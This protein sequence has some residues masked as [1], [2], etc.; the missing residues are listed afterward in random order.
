[1]KIA[2]CTFC[3]MRVIGLF[4]VAFLVT[5]CVAQ[6]DS[7][8]NTEKLRQA[9]AAYRHAEYNTAVNL[10][11]EVAATGLSTPALT[12]NTA[13]T[14]YQLGYYG[15]ALGEYRKALR[16]APRDP[17]IRANLQLARKKLGLAAPAV[18]DTLSLV[19]LR[20]FL[21]V[22][23]LQLI[24]ISVQTVFWFSFLLAPLFF[25]RRASAYSSA[26][27]AAA[28]V[29]FAFTLFCMREDAH[30]QWRI[31]APWQ[32]PQLVPAVIV[33]KEVT[34]H[35]GDAESFT[36]VLKLREGA[37]VY[38]AES[39]ND[40]VKVHIPESA[41][42]APAYPTASTRTAWVPARSLVLIR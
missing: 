26:V 15:R 12:Y 34:A 5:P 27:S 3:S 13:N 35:S 9:H 14:W 25:S 30:G 18:G 21:G 33:E 19:R 20:A 2:V 24:L 41:S 31:K 17:D 22:R 32:D 6:A 11:E 42:P 4:I 37:E 23:E 7:T 8:S 40:W 38:A 1:M 28:V 29:F 10:Y 39:R 16:L 36:A